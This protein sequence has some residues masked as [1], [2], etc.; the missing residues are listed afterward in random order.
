MQIDMRKIG[1]IMLLFIGLSLMNFSN[2]VY[3][4]ELVDSGLSLANDQSVYSTRDKI[5]QIK[6]VLLNTGS[7]SITVLTDRL[8]TEF[9]KDSNTYVISKGSMTA[10]YQGY[11]II[12]SLYK[13]AP[14]TL[15]PKE[16]TFVNHLVKKTFKDINKNTDFIVKYEIREKFGKRFNVWYGAVESGPIKPKIIK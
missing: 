12:E 3:S 5:L 1:I 8:D 4:E 11:N 9:L 16:G 13:F 6:I 10:K 15:K 7:D 2:L 14:V